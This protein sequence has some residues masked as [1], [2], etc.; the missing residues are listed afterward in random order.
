MVLITRDEPEVLTSLP[1]R[2]QDVAAL[3]DTALSKQNKA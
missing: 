3:R 1:R 2:P